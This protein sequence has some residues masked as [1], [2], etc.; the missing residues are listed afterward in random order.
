MHI[1]FLNLSLPFLISLF[2]EKN[3]YKVFPCFFENTYLFYRLFRMPNQIGSLYFSC[4][5]KWKKLGTL[6]QRDAKG[7]EMRKKSKF[8]TVRTVIGHRFDGALC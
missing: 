2:K 5:L 4:H 3:T 8:L 1:W 6:L 7:A